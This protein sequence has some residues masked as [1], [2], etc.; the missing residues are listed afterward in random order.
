MALW[1]S[2]KNSSDFFDD[3]ETFSPGEGGFSSEKAKAH[4]GKVG[5]NYCGTPN[6]SPAVEE[7]P[8][9]VVI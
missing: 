2:A 5:F 7:Q 8:D 1:Q 9:G 4:F 3:G 6:W